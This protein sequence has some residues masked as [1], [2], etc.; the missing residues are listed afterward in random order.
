MKKW[1]CIIWLS[2][3]FVWIVPTGVGGQVFSDD[4]LKFSQIINWIDKYYVDTV[5]K[6]ELV[7]KAIIEMLQNLDPHSTYLTKEEVKAMS[8]P[9]QGNFEGIG[10]S[11]NILNDTI[12]VI[13]PI[14]NGPSE[15]VGIRSGDRIVKI[16]G[17][18]VAGVGIKTSDVFAKLRGKKG[19]RVSVS[20]SR[21]SVSELLDFTITRDKIPIFSLDASYMINDEIGYIKLNRFSYTTMDEFRTA[22]AELKSEGMQDL[23]LDLGG[24]GGGYMDVAIKLA[25]QFLDD[26]KIIVYTEGNSHP[27]RKFSSTS[28]GEFLDGR[29]V[30]I[31]DQGSASAS[32]IV[33]GA[34]QDWDRGVIVG[35]RSFGK[36]LVQQPMPLLDSSMVRLTIARYYTPTGRLIQKPYEDGFEEYSKDLINRYNMGELLH[37]DSTVFPESLKYQTLVS[38]RPVYGGGG[39][40]PDYFVPLDTTYNSRYY[41]RLFSRGIINFFTLTYVD[42]H[43]KELQDKYPTFQSFL[44]GFT[45]KDKVLEDMIAYATEEDLDYSEEDFNISREHIRLVLKSYIAR[46]L[47]NSSEFYQVFNTSNPSV[48]KAIEVLNGQDIYQALLQPKQ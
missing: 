19:T 33:A 47:W 17:Q 5:N 28:R 27:K 9:L 10:I 15:K 22:L 36:G 1:L 26:R 31:I 12:F 18:S 16:E 20:I 2:V 23:V 43:R 45:I 42:D 11:F 41:S 40:M 21:R 46:D 8:E 14:P 38:Q 37:S 48:L 3:L 30:I 35:R 24:N 7:E 39:I 4:A 29:V 32:E 25:D 6:S 13:N 34:V 44:D